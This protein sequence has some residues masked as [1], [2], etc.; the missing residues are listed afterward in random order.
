MHSDFQII[1]KN[2]VLGTDSEEWIGFDLDGTLAVHVHSQGAEIGP[3]IIPIFDKLK[4]FLYT[5]KIK[6]KIFTARVS[7]EDEQSNDVQR[8]FIWQWLAEHGIRE[9]IEITCRKDMHMIMSYDDRILTV[10][11]NTGIVLASSEVK[12]KIPFNSI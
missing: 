7:M 2:Y 4:F 9:K 8:Y 5:A 11:E 3:P 12:F 6:C 10:Q 1:G